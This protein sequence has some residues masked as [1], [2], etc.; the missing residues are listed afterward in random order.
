MTEMAEQSDTHEPLSQFDADALREVA[1]I[2][3]GHAA[4]ALAQ[5]TGT[6][7]RIAVPTIDVVAITE[8][9]RLIGDQE[10]LMAGMYL[11]LVAEGSGAILLAFRR[12][13]ALNLID[14]MIGRQ[15]SKTH[16]LS[17][18]E[19]SA[20]REAGNILAGAFLSAISNFLNITLL[21]SVPHLA[22]D[23]VGALIQSL[24]VES[25][26][27]RDYALVMYIRFESDCCELG[28]HFL[29]VPDGTTMEVFLKAIKELSQC[30]GG[31]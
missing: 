9:P 17:E 14:L 26:V 15:T 3:A 29:M 12:E 4:T 11:R 1:T 6:T 24:L 27:D 21:A 28:G 25:D 31:V 10:E 22:F 7:V 5:L 23:M 18:L 20:L 19:Q 30:A 16:L 13:A 8:V 2:G